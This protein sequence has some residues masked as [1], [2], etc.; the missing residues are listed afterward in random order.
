VYPHLVEEAI[1]GHASVFLCGVVGL[2][3]PGGE[4]VVVGVQL[5]EGVTAS[6]QLAE[7]IL[8]ETAGLAEHEPAWPPTRSPSVSFPCQHSR[9]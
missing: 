4:Q 5:K 7:E 2:G 6:D 8:R 1:L 9:T 3:E